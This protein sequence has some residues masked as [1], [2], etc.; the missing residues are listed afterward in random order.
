MHIVSYMPWTLLSGCNPQQYIQYT[1]YI[2][3]VLT[4]L[5]ICIYMYYLILYVKHALGV[6]NKLNYTV[7]FKYIQVIRLNVLSR[8]IGTVIGAIS[9]L[10][11]MRRSFLSS[12]LYL[13]LYVLGDDAW[14]S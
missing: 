9:G 10:K 5:N 6:L 2:M 3:W 1:P 14:I 4:G 7:I 11:I 8:A 13:D 12:F